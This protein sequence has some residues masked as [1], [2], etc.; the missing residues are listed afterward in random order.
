M[1][2]K[3]LTYAQADWREH[4]I[5]FSI[6]V[7]CWI[8]NLIIAIIFNSTVPQVPFLILYPM[9]IGGT[10]ALSWCAYSRGSFGMLATFLMLAGIGC[11][12]YM[13]VLFI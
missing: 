7:L 2:N 12:G 6:E 11:Y 5:R 3:I 9:W 10:L 8:N 1:I 13:K 4:P